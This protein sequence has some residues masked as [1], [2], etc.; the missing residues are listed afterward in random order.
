MAETVKKAKAP[1]KPRK[2]A[3]KKEKVAPAAKPAMPS[4]EE[5]EKLARAYWEQRGYQDGFA[6]QDWLR[7]ER[8]LHRMAS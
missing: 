8:E 7:A 3:T 5:I 2:T 4:R 1:A 6:E